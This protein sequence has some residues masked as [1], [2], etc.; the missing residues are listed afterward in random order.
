[1]PIAQKTAN[2]LVFRRF[3]ANEPHPLTKRHAKE[4]P[5][6]ILT[7]TTLTPGKSRNSVSDLNLPQPGASPGNPYGI[8]PRTLVRYLYSPYQG[9]RPTRTPYCTL[10]KI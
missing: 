2:K 1:M 5:Y 4:P 7:Y 10:T 8:L 3:Q 9:G 6:G